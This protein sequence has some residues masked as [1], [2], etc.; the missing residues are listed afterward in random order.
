[1]VDVG[2]RVLGTLCASM[3]RR[4]ARRRDHLSG[5]SGESSLREAA[6]HRSAR[7]RTSIIVALCRTD[8]TDAFVASRSSRRAR[9]RSTEQGIAAFTTPTVVHLAWCSLSRPY[10]ARR[11]RHSYH[12]PRCSASSRP[13]TLYSIIVVRR[14]RRLDRYTLV[15]EDWLWYTLCPL[16]AYLALVAVAILL[17]GSAA[18]ALFLIGGVMAL[19]MFNGIRN[20]WDIVTYIAIERLPQQDE[21]NETKE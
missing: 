2:V 5:L 14:Q 8:R 11:G 16:I 3:R 15:V 1:M 21:R 19:L 13:G 10:S 4:K 7:G 20:A 17:P 18:P 9:Q 6:C 12:P